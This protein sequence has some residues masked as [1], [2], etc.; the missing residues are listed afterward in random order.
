MA[1]NVHA[2]GQ[3]LAAL[4]EPADLVS[5]VACWTI[6]VRMITFVRSNRVQ[7]EAVGGARWPSLWYWYAGAFALYGVAHG[8]RS[9]SALW[10]DTAP[11]ADAIGLMTT[12]VITGTAIALALSIRDARILWGHPGTRQEV[13]DAVHELHLA[14]QAVLQEAE[15]ARQHGS[16]R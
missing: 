1:L 6:A 7:T 12:A 5:V 9:L 16:Q 3:V 14:A 10:P 15:G 11:L 13:K 8:L 4:R 2:I